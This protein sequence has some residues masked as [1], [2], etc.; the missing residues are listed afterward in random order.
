MINGTHWALSVLVAAVL[1]HLPT[2]AQGQDWTTYWKNGTR[3]ES[4]DGEIKLKIG[5]RIQADFA[6]QSGDRQLEALGTLEG[7]SEFRRARLFAEGT[8]Y[9]RFEFKAQYDFAN[10]DVQVKDLYVGVVGLPG[11]G[12]IRVG[13][14]KEP[15]GLEELTSSKYLAFLER[16]S[17]SEAFA[18][19]RNTGVLFHNTV[20][21][22]RLTWAIGAF[23]DA[24]NSG[25]S[26]GDEGNITA[27][28]TG[29]PVYASEGRQLLHLGLSFSSR[30]PVDDTARYRARPESHLAPRF[31][32]TGSFGAQG[33]DL[34]GL[35]AAVVAGPFWAQ[36][37][38]M[39]ADIDAP[40]LADPTLGGV[41]LQAGFFLTGENRVYKTSA[42]AFDR[43]KP[44]RELF[45]KGD[46]AGAG[47]WEIALR[48]STLDLDDAALLG[49]EQDTVAVALNWY[50]N[51]ATRLMLNYVEPDV[52][53]GGK[54]D[55][56]LLRLQVDF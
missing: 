8:L 19:S 15:F 23:Q 18:P 54:G 47:A 13:H 20:A 40:T 24:D 42:A 12:G 33:I 25:R 5:G 43:L 21:G 30:S 44:K 1:T 3:I 22:D 29:L 52:D 56:V 28:L 9:G 55:L 11:I 53:G 17:V 32:D 14:V 6:A 34:L 36:G 2:P 50:P 48:Y 46:K 39:Q 45:G 27:R 49:G 37:E 10:S 41:S 16:S 7:G 35:E 4:E 26:T 38:W 31:V 51:S